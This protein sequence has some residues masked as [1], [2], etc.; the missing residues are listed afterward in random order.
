M[1]YMCVAIPSG[2]APPGVGPTF[3]PYQGATPP[4]PP[5]S[6][7]H[8]TGL[9][10][11]CLVGTYNLVATYSIILFLIIMAIGYAFG[12]LALRG[13]VHRAMTFE[14]QIP[15]DRL[16]AMDRTRFQ[17]AAMWLGAMLVIGGLILVSLGI[18][19]DVKMNISLLGDVQTATPGIAA[20]FIGLFVVMLGRP[21]GRRSAEA[22][23]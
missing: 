6:I 23:G 21:A 20:I 3:L 12:R 9:G 1:P 11:M 4:P 5:E 8:I 18:R 13:R 16:E 19:G 15:I 22:R 7:S 2:A 10:D 14:S 17:R